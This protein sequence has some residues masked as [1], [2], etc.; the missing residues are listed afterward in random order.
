MPA[1]G[2]T[3]LTPTDRANIVIQ[4]DMRPLTGKTT[5]D[6]AKEFGVQPSTVK[7][8][9]ANNIP[10]EAK[11]IYKKKR[12]KLEELAMATTVAALEKGREL[13]LASDNPRHLS[14][15]AA[16]GK[17]SDTVY[18]LETHQPTVIQEG[19]GAE[20]HALDFIR[21]LLERMDLENALSHFMKASLEPLVPEDRKLSIRQRI[22]S[23][24][25]KLL[26]P[27]KV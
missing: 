25:L 13:I 27:A 3:K 20:S 15:I 24:E 4:R 23:G 10:R 8:M 26:P 14:G 21:I 1:K 22:E 5:E 18:R 12:A 7:D 9:T 17:L 19:L 6:I 11:K 2:T 16:M